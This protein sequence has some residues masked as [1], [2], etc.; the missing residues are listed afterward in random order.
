M[1][2]GVRN[3]WPSVDRPAVFLLSKL[4]GRSVGLSVGRSVGRL[5]LLPSAIL[6]GFQAVA[7]GPT[8][9]EK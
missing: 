3:G 5:W 2:R 9:C 1:E 6:A 7:S 4:V 8:F